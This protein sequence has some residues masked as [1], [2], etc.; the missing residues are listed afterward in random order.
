MID[1]RPCLMC[2]SYSQAGF[3]HYA[4]Q[5]NYIHPEPT[6]THLRYSFEGDHP[7]Q[8]THLTLFHN[9]IHGYWLDF[10]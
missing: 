3:Y 8:T 9:R 5:M 2:K 1:F 7:S 4:L 10:S 6:I